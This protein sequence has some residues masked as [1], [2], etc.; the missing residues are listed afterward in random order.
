M[1]SLYNVLDAVNDV[2]DKSIIL[3]KNEKAII[4][5]DIDVNDLSGPGGILNEIEETKS[6][7]SGKHRRTSSIPRTVKP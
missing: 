4:E 5:S 1:K 7:V 3:S 2:L 6:E